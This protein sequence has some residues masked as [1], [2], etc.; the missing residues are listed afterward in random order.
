MFLSIEDTSSYREYSQSVYAHR[1]P[2]FHD[3]TKCTRGGEYQ[4]ARGWVEGN[5]HSLH[6]IAHLLVIATLEGLGAEVSHNPFRPEVIFLIKF[7]LKWPIS[8]S[9]ILKYKNSNPQSK[10]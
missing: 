6:G 9:N 3:F 1:H 2:P 5:T 10:C 8:I 7:L 4:D